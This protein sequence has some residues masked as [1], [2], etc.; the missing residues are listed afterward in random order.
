M[1]LQNT[2][3][4]P[5]QTPSPP[6]SNAN[7]I[8]N[9]YCGWTLS[10]RRVRDALQDAAAEACERRRRRNQTK[11]NSAARGPNWTVGGCSAIARTAQ[12]GTTHRGDLHGRVSTLLK[13]L[14]DLGDSADASDERRSPARVLCQIPTEFVMEFQQIFN[15]IP[16][17][18]QRQAA[19]CVFRF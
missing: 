1:A 9:R 17:E 18:F 15:R 10:P 4:R 16:T 13:N 8:L 5:R 3:D 2:L 19:I 11:R 14:T 12:I 6:L 7:G